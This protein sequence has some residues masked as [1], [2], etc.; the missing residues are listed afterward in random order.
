MPIEGL[1]LSNPCLIY[2]ANLK[3]FTL[4]QLL[5]FAHSE[6]KFSDEIAQKLEIFN[7]CC[8]AEDL[9][10]IKF[11]QSTAVRTSLCARSK[12][13][14]KLKHACGSAKISRATFGNA[15][16]M[17]ARNGFET[18]EELI[19]GLEHNVQNVFGLGPQKIN[20][21]FQRL[22]DLVIALDSE[23]SEHANTRTQLGLDKEVAT[24][25]PTAFK[26]LDI[27]WLRL[28]TKSIYFRRAGIN[29]LG[30][31]FNKLGEGNFRLRTIQID[32]VGAKTLKEAKLTFDALKEAMTPDGRLN[33]EQYANNSNLILIGGGS[34][35][36]SPK[37]FL[38]QLDCIWGNL[39]NAFDDIVDRTII[40]QRLNKQGNDRVTLEQIGNM[41]DP[42]ITRERVRQK[43]SKI[44][45]SVVLGLIFDEYGKQKFVFNPSFSNYWKEL[46][47]STALTEIE[48]GEFLQL[49]S[50]TWGLS[51][52]ELISRLP[53]ILQ[54]VTGE[55]SNHSADVVSEYIDAKLLYGLSDQARLVP[56]ASVITRKN[57]RLI[58][59]FGAV[60][61]LGNVLDIIKN[62]FLNR[63]PS[64]PEKRLLK[65]LTSVANAIDD[66]GCLDWKIYSKQIQKP[67]IFDEPLTIASFLEN[68]PRDIIT[69]INSVQFRTHGHKIITERTIVDRSKRKTLR[70]LADELSIFQ[71]TVS[72]LERHSLNRLQEILF[73]RDFQNCDAIISPRYL[74]HWATLANTFTESEENTEEFV[75]SIV[76]NYNLNRNSI[77]SK[78]NIVVPILTGY[79]HRR[80]TRYTSNSTTVKDTTMPSFD[81]SSK[82]V[83]RGFRKVH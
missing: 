74:S 28:H 37:S 26:N 80:M 32:S 22:S 53:A 10:I 25:L 1:Q 40:N 50:K 63:I 81:F 69:I 60:E 79:S 55:V 59:R 41:S 7:E 34:N 58:N 72:Q 42:P 46:A 43:E 38:D 23:P 8:D 19:D 77:V 30:D 47:N 75:K 62:E 29:D 78:L 35:N 65:S 48:I 71:P 36:I 33:I 52:D 15:G 51:I 61:T 3:I 20:D 66:Q 5:N 57:L 67:L 24:H 44:L 49:T 70:I 45:R 54:L 39:E 82:I 64:N 18:L 11:W 76:S 13:L 73:A 83:L 6:S 14:R 56:A 16:A 4:L 12:Q 2:L 21:L 27:G 31:F 17:L 68:L 9:N